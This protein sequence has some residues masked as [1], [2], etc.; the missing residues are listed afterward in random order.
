M[1]ECA[2]CCESNTIKGKTDET[3][4]CS[5][6]ECRCHCCCSDPVSYTHLLKEKAV[7]NPSI[8]DL[9][10]TCFVHTGIKTVVQPESGFFDP[11][12]PE[13]NNRVVPFSVRE[14]QIREI[15]DLG[16]EK[17]YL[18]LDGWAEPGYDNQ[19]PDYTPACQAA[20]GWEDMKSLSLI[21][22]C[23]NSDPLR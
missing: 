17:V 19:H 14:Q 11:Q 3:I 1:P 12:N 8:H 13:K 20:G 21:H 10:G 23:K 22:I 9:V 4:D 15:H 2:G 5:F 7:Q 6:F 16:V 18:H